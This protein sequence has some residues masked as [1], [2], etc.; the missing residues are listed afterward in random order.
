[1]CQAY[2]KIRTREKYQVQWI[3]EANPIETE[4]TVGIFGM[5][6]LLLVCY[7]LG[8]KLNCL[9]SNFNSRGV[10]SR[11]HF[12]VF[13][14]NSAPWRLIGTRLGGNESYKLPGAF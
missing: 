9:C 14:H 5:F 6:V 11:E 10:N 7:F 1:M 2:A 3:G 13:G 12:W 4:D 8:P